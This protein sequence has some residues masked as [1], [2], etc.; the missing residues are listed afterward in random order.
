MKDRVFLDSDVILDIAIAR[1]PFL[2][3]AANLLSQIEAG[4]FDGYTSSIIFTNIYY[5]QKKLTSHEVAV[6]FLKKLRLILKVLP[7][8]D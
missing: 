6:S 4:I 1:K 7:V 8:D 2:L 3:A 5:I